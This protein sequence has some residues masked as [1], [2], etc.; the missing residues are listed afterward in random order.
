MTYAGNTKQ[1]QI[2]SIEDK[3]TTTH[4]HV[5]QKTE[6]LTREEK[7][8]YYLAKIDEMHSRYYTD[9]TK[10]FY[11]L[12]LEPK[13]SE[14]ELSLRE[15]ILKKLLDESVELIFHMP[16]VIVL[17]DLAHIDPRSLE[18]SEKNLKHNV[19][20]S[21]EDS[22][23]VHELVAKSQLSKLQSKIFTY[24]KGGN[25]LFPSGGL[26]QLE[27]GSVLYGQPRY[28]KDYNLSDFEYE[29]LDTPEFKKKRLIEKKYETIYLHI[30]AA[31][32][33]RKMP[34]AFYP[35]S[36]LREYADQT[37]LTQLIHDAETHAG[38]QLKHDEL[39]E[40]YFGSY[41]IWMTG[42]EQFL[43]NKLTTLR[44]EAVK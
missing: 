4:E 40:Q 27:D 6:S 11:L 31:G 5:T 20:I 33:L 28:Y 24:L 18:S 1:S 43:Q 19:S 29:E 17:K 14:T 42:F 39:A 26:I 25:N 37:G 13:L 15:E 32:L 10:R 44:I 35:K 16:P 12:A 7:E 3:T 36:F 21:Q 38:K 30:K 41:D 8:K 34:F 9:Q 22:E 2:N 23:L